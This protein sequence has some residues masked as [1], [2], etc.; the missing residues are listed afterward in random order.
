MP[1]GQV[2]S[3]FRTQPSGGIR[4]GAASLDVVRTLPILSGMDMD[5]DKLART[6][7]Y[8]ELAWAD[9]PRALADPTD[10]WPATDP[11]PDEARLRLHAETAALSVY[12]AHLKVSIGRDVES[13]LAEIRPTDPIGSAGYGSLGHLMR[14]ADSALAPWMRSWRASRQRATNRLTTQRWRSS[15]RQRP[16]AGGRATSRAS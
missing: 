13:R 15:T 16:I 14:A 9:L 2:A 4:P 12:L 5:R 11:R 10:G 8:L 6:A 7:W 3:Q 1:P